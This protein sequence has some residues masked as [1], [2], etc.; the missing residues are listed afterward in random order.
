MSAWKQ[1]DAI[2]A[3]RIEVSDEVGGKTLFQYSPFIGEQDGA[4]AIFQIPQTRI[5]EDTLKVY[6][7]GVLLTLGVDYTLD[8]P[9]VGQLTFAAPPAVENSL[10]ATLSWLFF[11]DA[12]LDRHLNRAANDLNYPTYHTDE[13]TVA[14]SEATAAIA[15]I[16]DG[17]KT[18]I[19]MLGAYHASHALAQRF[20]SKYDVSVGEQDFTLSQLADHYEKLASQLYDR[21]IKARDEFYKAS[22]QQYR[23]SVAA[24]GWMLPQVTPKR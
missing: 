20:A 4:N 13:A 19:V 12:E 10:T 6:S 21:G 14:D 5:A 24:Q 3:V 1:A 23:A 8:D 15:D 22:G 2:R 7:D 11:L 18:A 16:P 9:M 17:L